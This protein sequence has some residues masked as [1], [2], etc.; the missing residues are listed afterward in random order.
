MSINKFISKL[1][2]NP[3]AIDQI[4]F[5]TKRLHQEQ[6]IRRL[7]LFFIILTF[8][9]QM[10][11]TAVPARQS[12]A[13]SSPNDVI[14]GGVNNLSQLKSKYD[15][16]ADVKALYNRFG[17]TKDDME[18]SKV[19]NTSFNFQDQGSKGTRTV[20]RI[21]FAS[22]KDHN[23]GKFAGTT[24]YS[25]S[26]SEWQD[27][28]P[29]YFM[30]KHQGTDGNWWNVWILKDCGNIAY[31]PADAPEKPDKPDK[32]TEPTPQVACTSLSAD[33]RQG[34]RSFST[35]LTA[36]YSANKANLVNGITFDFGDGQVY[37]HNG[38]IIDHTYTNT[39][40]ETKTYTA[41]VTINST[42][43]D[44]T[45]TACQVAITV[46]PEKCPTNPNLNPDDPGCKVCP[47]NSSIPSNDPKCQPPCPYNASLLAN[48]PAC[49]EK[50]PYNPN[51][52]KD[53]P[54]CKEA[55]KCPY[56]PAL[57]PEDPKCYCPDDKNLSAQDPKCST[58]IRE[59]TA[60]NITQNLDPT[61]TLA[62]KAKAS[63]VIEYKLITTNNNT[64]ERSKLIIEDYIG[65]VLDYADLDV[66]FLEQQG[67]KYNAI[68]KTVYW[69][70]QTLPAKGKLE[71]TFRITM[72]SSIPVTHAPS[73]SATTYDCKIQNGYGNEIAL[74]VDCP[75][76]KQV[77]TLPNTGP[78]QSIFFAFAITSIAGYFFARSRLFTKELDIIKK[79]Y[80]YGG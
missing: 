32:P 22:T 34:T 64:V 36:A 73:A 59:K 40:K 71:K 56:N 41:K 51:L 74:N 48:D 1:S 50:C 43:G 35:R 25:R 46:L 33:P 78:G 6:S 42:L 53:D 68:T 10:I 69:E 18:A 57:T 14:Y 60:T 54:N 19:Q 9:V 70:N 47:Y 24:F 61:K 39:S 5:Y 20:G 72:K 8:F 80:T 2:F 38:V 13:A 21:N 79:E 27:S 58:P 77:E 12:L 23:L 52:A 63:D 75:V 66:A 65:D 45:S 17:I 30:G 31:R 7:G 4:S 26:A 28:T 67:G 16:H 3:S 29:A 62:A 15:A 49:K 55:P 11:A 76:L 37:K 44:K